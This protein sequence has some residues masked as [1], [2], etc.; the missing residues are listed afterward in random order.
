MAGP[1]R[2]DFTGAN[3]LLRGDSWPFVDTAVEFTDSRT[4]LTGGVV[5]R[6]TVKRFENQEDPAD[7]DPLVDAATGV[8]QIDSASRGGITILGANSYRA[9]FPAAQT[10]L[11]TP[12][13]YHYDVVIDFSAAES[14]TLNYG[15]IETI[16]DVTD[17]RTP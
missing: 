12:G 10:E 2:I 13:R 14:N 7:V 3:G 16:E 5:L 6:A 15:D 11:L 1:K 8:M 9:V 4:L 17:A